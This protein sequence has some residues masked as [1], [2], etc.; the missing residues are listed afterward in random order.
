[1]KKM[2]LAACVL[3]AAI[4]F[5]CTLSACAEKDPQKDTEKYT[6]TFESNGG[7][8]VASQEVE[9]GGY[10]TK[11]EDPERDGYLFT[12]WY[13][14]ASLAEESVYDFG[15]AVNSDLTLYAGWVDAE[16]AATATFYWNYEGADEE[17]YEVVYFEDGER[18]SEPSDPDRGEGYYFAG[19]YEDAELTTEYSAMRRYEGDQSFYAKWMTIYTFEAENTQLTGLTEDTELGLADALGNKVGQGYSNNP[20][21]TALIVAEGASGAQA[22]GGYYVSSLYYNGA[23]LEWK[24]TSDAAVDD[25]VLYLRLSAEYYDATLTDDT[26]LVDVNGEALSFND[27][28]FDGVITEMSSQE[29]RP[30]TNYGIGT[31]SLKE[32]EN[33]VRLTVNNSNAPGTTGTMRATAPMFDCIYVYST[34]SLT[35][36]KYNTSITG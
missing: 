17:V 23:Y 21:G 32:G 6:V 10:A 8:A 7:S 5:T 3:A 14:D 9:A 29:K 22:S 20:A 33:T 16:G 12:A 30:F 15:T 35:M 31:I 19:W 27:I 36:E 2:L 18:V 25:A 34:S 1:M 4:T 24:I 11:P 13:D 28:V 26:F